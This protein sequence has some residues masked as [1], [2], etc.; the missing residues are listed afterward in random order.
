[1]ATS[2]AS[3]CTR[4]MTAGRGFIALAALIFGKW[5]PLPTFL[6]CLFFGFTET[7]QIQLQSATF[8]DFEVPIQAIQALPYLVTLI[9]LV[10]FVGQSRPPRA[11]IT[12]E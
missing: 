10:G 7:M 4:D 5:K 3:Q 2:H 12:G 6:A 1:M 11:I 8:G 9:V